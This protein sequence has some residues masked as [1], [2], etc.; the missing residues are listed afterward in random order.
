MS[1]PSEPVVGSADEKVAP[2]ENIQLEEQG[3]PHSYENS[4]T[5]RSSPS[6]IAGPTERPAQSIT[7]VFIRFLIV[8][9]YCSLVVLCTV[10]GY[11][12]IRTH[13]LGDGS[14]TLVDALYSGLV[15]G[16]VLGIPFSRK[17]GVFDKYQNRW[18]L[19]NTNIA[20]GRLRRGILEFLLCTILTLLMC[21]SALIVGICIQKAP[22]VLVEHPD[23]MA[24]LEHI[25]Y[26]LYT[27]SIG[28]LAILSTMSMLGIWFLVKEPKIS[29]NVKEDRFKIIVVWSVSL[30]SKA[31]FG[32]T[33]PIASCGRAS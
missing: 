9:G 11:A 31:A 19:Y 15:G 7:N 4:E 13:T 32:L 26:D 21:W 25:G 29:Q 22:I 28:V 27:S 18:K 2:A 5:G 17:G 14:N 8:G 6:P 12:D 10:Y 20:C 30:S 33:R 16:T 3:P 24:L 1:K 23:M